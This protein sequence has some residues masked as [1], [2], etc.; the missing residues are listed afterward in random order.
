MTGFDVIIYLFQV[1]MENCWQIFVATHIKVN[2]KPMKISK[3][4]FGGNTVV[5]GF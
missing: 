3:I 5:K 1:F 4:F 2:S